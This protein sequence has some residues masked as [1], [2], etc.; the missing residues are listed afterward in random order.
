[1]IQS[2]QEHI[3]A[4]KDGA[5]TIKLTKIW[6]TFVSLHHTP[7][8]CPSMHNDSDPHENSGRMCDYA[9]HLLP[10]SNWHVRCESDDYAEQAYL[11]FYMEDENTLVAMDVYSP[12]TFLVLNRVVNT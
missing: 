3:F 11:L 1:M 2:G 9:S 5:K 12:N 6:D 7:W 4:S 10:E 8:K